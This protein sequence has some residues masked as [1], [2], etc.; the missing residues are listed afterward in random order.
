MFINICYYRC[1]N[2]LDFN[3]PSQNLMCKTLMCLI[4]HTQSLDVSP[5][6]H[7]VPQSQLLHHI[8]VSLA[9]HHSQYD[10]VLPQAQQLYGTLLY[11]VEVSLSGHYNQ[12]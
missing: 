12:Q 4:I 2:V 9:C 5:H 1:Y 10:V 11:H 6:P 7:P 8:G 3:L